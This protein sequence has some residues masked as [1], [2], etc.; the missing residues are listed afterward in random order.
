MNHVGEDLCSPHNKAVIACEDLMNQSRHI[1][2]VMHAQTSLEILKNR[3]WLK[4]SIDAVRWFTFQSC[5]FRGHD[6]RP[7]S[8]NRGNFI[9]MVKVLAS[10]NGD[11]AET[12]LENA[13][14]N[15]KY[16]SPLIQK[17]L[18]HILST[19]VRN[20]IREDIGDAKFCILV[21]ETRDESKRKQMALVLRFVD[22]G[23][24]LRECFFCLVH[25]RDTTSLTLKK[26][27][28]AILSRHSLNIQN[29]QG[30]GY[31]GASNMH[32]EWNGLQALF[33]QDCP[34]AY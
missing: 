17:E 19:K 29:I 1:D 16:T 26:E 34:Y 3:L 13:P 22:E 32:G 24:V 9:E 10:Y 14:K 30:Q 25:V 5:A 23:G 28:V 12:V 6:E 27:L 20:K 18:L 11:A 33:L 7:N 4:T 15:A 2:K 31:D 8:K 21:D